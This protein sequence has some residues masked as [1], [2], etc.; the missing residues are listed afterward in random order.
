MRTPTRPYCIGV[1]S[2]HKHFMTRL[3]SPNAIEIMTI[4]V[5]DFEFHATE[6][7]VLNK[8]EIKEQVFRF[9]PGTTVYLVASREMLGWYYILIA[10]PQGMGCT[11]KQ[12][13]CPHMDMLREHTNAAVA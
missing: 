4:D 7:D 6:I 11:C 3:D 12:S 5:P 10:T 1:S 8:V 9:K 2:Q 13:R